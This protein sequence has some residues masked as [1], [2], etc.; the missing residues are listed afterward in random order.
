MR[1]FPWTTA[2]TSITACISKHSISR[3][4]SDKL[5]LQKVATT[6]VT[7]LCRRRRVSSLAKGTTSKKKKPFVNIRKERDR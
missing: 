4:G 5:S 6:S 7:A 3:A 2:M 1:V